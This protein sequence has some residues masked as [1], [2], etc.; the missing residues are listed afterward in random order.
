MSSVRVH[1]SARL[2]KCSKK[3]WI[4]ASHL[5]VEIIGWQILGVLQEGTELVVGAESGSWIAGDPKHAS[6][7]SVPI[8]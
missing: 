1:A 2:R 4:R 3:T 7:C 8:I 5:R 6:Q